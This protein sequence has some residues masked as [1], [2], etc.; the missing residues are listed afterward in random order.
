MMGC[1][2]LLQLVNGL[3]V[4]GRLLWPSVLG[5]MTSDDRWKLKI[6]QEKKTSWG[7]WGRSG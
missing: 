7:V 1:A 2:H 6:S 4:W 5:L 3:A